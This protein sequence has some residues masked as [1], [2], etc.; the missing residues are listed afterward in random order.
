M[1][2]SENVKHTSHRSSGK[3]TEILSMNRPDSRFD[4]RPGY[5]FVIPWSLVHVGGVNQVVINLAREME[6][7]GAYKPIV[8]VT[9]W[10]ATTPIWEEEQGIQVVRW[11]IRPY[12]PFASLKERLM[13]RLWELT[14]KAAFYDFC[15]KH[16]VKVINPHYPVDTSFTLLRLKTITRLNSRLFLSFHGTDVSNICNSPLQTV[17]RWKEL[18]AN[19]DSIVA[20]SQDLG[21]RIRNIAGEHISTNI[22]HNG[23]AP[24]MLADA[25]GNHDRDDQRC[26]LCVG[27]F[28]NKKG[29]DTL[30]RAFSTISCEFDDLTLILVGANGESLNNFKR[31]AVELNVEDR[32][33]FYTDIPHHEIN[34]FYRHAA[35]F[36]L[37]S[38]QEALGIVL[39]EA[40]AF[41]LPVVASNVGGIP[42]VISDGV[43]GRLFPSG[44]VD[45]LAQCLKELLLDRNK[46]V[47][48]GKNLHACVVDNFSW[49]TATKKYFDLVDHAAN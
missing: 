2:N 26:V 15:R 38:R 43:T 40:G 31:L 23:V 8:L 37:P 41:A 29:Q 6:K 21:Q 34:K 48:L 47:N 33:R 28:D 7:S 16:R 35:V 20:C 24:E 14:F 36:C 32:V 11:R 49:H 3:G 39:L 22:I 17:K 19:S 5:L 45:R 9:D 13:Y 18:L 42:E 30:I 25:D 44:D 27:K 1:S 4:A 46:A 12:Q 10:N